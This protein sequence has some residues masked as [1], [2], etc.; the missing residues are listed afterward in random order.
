MCSIYNDI[1]EYVLCFLC[2][3]FKKHPEWKYWIIARIN[4]KLLASTLVLNLVS[5]Y[6]CI[7]LYRIYPVELCAWVEWFYINHREKP[8]NPVQQGCYTKEKRET[9]T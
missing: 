1:I 3:L 6:I 8:V 7:V 5:K 4:V 9:I 2:D